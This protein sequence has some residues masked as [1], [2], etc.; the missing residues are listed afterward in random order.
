MT[1]RSP[2]TLQLPQ[3]YI[4]LDIETTGL[5]PAYASITEVGAVRI[6]DGKITD[7]YSQLIDPQRHIPSRITQLTGI[8]DDMVGGQ[9]VIDEVLPEFVDWIGEYPLIGHN[10]RFD[11]SFLRE[12]S[13][14]ILGHA[15]HFEQRPV[16]TMVIDK[17]LF[18]T[19]R[20]RLVDLIQRYG[21]ADSE[22]HRALSDATQ[23]YQCLEWQRRYIKVSNSKPM[24][25]AN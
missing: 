11:L 19:E 6:Q 23:T 15:R 3:E 24:L 10:V 18:P 9:P 12:A 25:F 17:Q 8:S 5:S 16:D 22:E 14:R 2:R 21:I 1:T 4:A 20:H 13:Q 7:R